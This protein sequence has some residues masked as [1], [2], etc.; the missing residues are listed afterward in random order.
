MAG[1]NS[2]SK[3][4]LKNINPVL[5]IGTCISKIINANE[6]VIGEKQASRQ[7]IAQARMVTTHILL[8][9]HNGTATSWSLLLLASY[10]LT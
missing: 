10:V 8:Q 6:S 9:T 2:L 7:V 1:K 5:L 3:R 4:T